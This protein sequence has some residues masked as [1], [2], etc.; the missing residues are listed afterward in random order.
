MLTISKCEALNAQAAREVIES[1]LAREYPSSLHAFP[2]NDLADLFSSYGKLGEAFFVAL[3]NGKVIGTAGV[4]REDDRSA[5]LRRLFVLPEYRR[6]QVGS[7]LVERA[8]QFCREVGY[9]E[10]I[11]KTT[12]TMEN[13]IRLCEKKGF[14]TKACLDLGPLKLLKY[15]LNLKN[16]AIRNGLKKVHQ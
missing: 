10:L 9:Q 14:V 15:A 8:I 16:H 2:P 6:K 3:E 12:S 11:F 5:F 4:K 1:I 7:E 13:A